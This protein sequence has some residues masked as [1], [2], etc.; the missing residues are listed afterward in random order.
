MHIKSET[1]NLEW[2]LTSVI[3]ELGKKKHNVFFFFSKFEAI[4]DYT[5]SSLRLNRKIISSKQFVY[6]VDPI[7]K[8]R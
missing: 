6:I 3:T 7:S 1:L 8:L 4:L 2:Q 5:E